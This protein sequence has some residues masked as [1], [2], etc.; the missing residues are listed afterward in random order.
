[1][2]PAAAEAAPDRERCDLVALV[3]EIAERH[4]AALGPAACRISLEA[5]QAI[6]GAWDPAA[7]EEIISTLLLGAAARGAG[8]SV[9]IAVRALD[10]RARL[11]FDEDRIGGQ[12]TVELPRTRP[13]DR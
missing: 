2:R 12:V 13:A 1:V 4:G 11:T 9:K 6:E 8:R 3:R 10:D 5:A 7:V